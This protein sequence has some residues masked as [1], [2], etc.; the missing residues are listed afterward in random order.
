M[1]ADLTEETRAV[2]VDL[3]RALPRCNHCFDAATCRVASA[4]DWLMCDRHEQ[5]EPRYATRPLQQAG[6]V[7][8]ANALLTATTEP[9][10]GEER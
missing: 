6:L 7:R 2:I 5:H 3:L 10:G 8:R 1:A 9:T 4:P